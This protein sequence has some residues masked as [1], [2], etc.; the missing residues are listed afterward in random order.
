MD[1]WVKMTLESG[2][3][4][5][6]IWN[7][8]NRIIQYDSKNGAAIPVWVIFARLEFNSQISICN[9]SF[10]CLAYNDI[11]YRMMQKPRTHQGNTESGVAK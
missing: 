7:Q 10:D 9:R 4:E 11:H 2:G 3:A 6:L 8:I 5:G 1:S